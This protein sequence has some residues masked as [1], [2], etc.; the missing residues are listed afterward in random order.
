MRITAAAVLAATTLPALLTG[1]HTVE[2]VRKSPV[3]WTASYG[4]PFDIMANCLAAQAA[5]D[6][7]VTPQLYQSQQRAIVTLGAKGTYS[8]VAEYQVRQI[9]PAAIEVTWRTV[10]GIASSDAARAR[11]DR[12][13][14]EAMA[15]MPPPAPAPAPLPATTAAPAWAPEPMATPPGA[16]TPGR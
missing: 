6:F 3:V 13:A 16:P 14:R 5:R 12:C 7:D 10:S 1:C 2:D 9:S 4:V 8:L 11:A 15:S